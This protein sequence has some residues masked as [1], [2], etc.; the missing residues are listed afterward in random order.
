MSTP[1]DRIHGELHNK[2]TDFVKVQKNR[3]NVFCRV[4]TSLLRQ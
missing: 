1:P 3:K 2:Y 4:A